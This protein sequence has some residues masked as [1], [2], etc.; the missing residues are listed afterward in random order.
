M[1]EYED[2]GIF[3]DAKEFSDTA[4]VVIARTGGENADLPTSITD[5]DTFEY[6]GGWSGYSGDSK[7]VCPGPAIQSAP[8]MESYSSN[9]PSSIALAEFTTTT[10]L[11][12]SSQTM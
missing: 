12:N 1:Q 10:T 11:S 8:L 5:E 4:L 9:H 7:P 3:E 6:T 2:A